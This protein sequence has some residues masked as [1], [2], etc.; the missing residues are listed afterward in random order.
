MMCVCV[1]VLGACVTCVCVH[2]TGSGE[3][4]RSSQWVVITGD[5]CCE[6]SAGSL[7]AAPHRARDPHLHRQLL[8]CVS[9][10]V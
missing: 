4:D 9:L 5:L 2:V 6:M 8:T 10:W 3:R 1:S 7:R